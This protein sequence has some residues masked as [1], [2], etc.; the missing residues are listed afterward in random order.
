M[1]ATTTRAALAALLFAVALPAPA[2]TVLADG[3]VRKVDRENAKLTL[4]HGEIKS[5][6]MPP[7]TMVFGVRDPKLLDQLKAGDKIRF[8]AVDEG[9]GKLTVTAIEPVKQDRR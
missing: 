4:K 2:Q 3:E 1:I 7:M 5:L 9:G 6:D 8:S